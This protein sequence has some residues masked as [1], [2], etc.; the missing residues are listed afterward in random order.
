MSY[1]TPTWLRRVYRE[2]TGV[3]LFDRLIR[4][5]MRVSAMLGYNPFIQLGVGRTDG[6]TLLAFAC[7]SAR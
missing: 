6:E 3:R 7:K 4:L 2:A 5:A 1:I